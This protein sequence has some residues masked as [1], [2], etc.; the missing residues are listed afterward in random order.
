MPKLLIADGMFL[1]R[2]AQSGFGL[3]DHPVTFNFF[4]GF[5]ALVEKHAPDSV[6]FVLEGKTDR[7]AEFAD[8]KANRSI[9]VDQTDPESVK[10]FKA[11]QE[12]FRQ[13]D[14]IVALLKNALPVVV[15]RHPRYEADDVI[16]TM[17]KLATDVG[18]EVIIVSGDSDFNQMLDGK[19]NL[20][21]WNP[22]EKDWVQTPDCD[23]LMWKALKG[24][25]SDNIP[26]IPGVGAVTASRAVTDE[27]FREKLLSEG[28][29]RKTFERNL[30]LIKLRS[31]SA[32]ELD[33]LER[34]KGVP[35]WVEAIDAF[36]RW[37]F[38]SFFKQTKTGTQW[39][40]FRQVFGKLK[41]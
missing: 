34:S 22:I 31:L 26:G 7:K 16:Y 21:I 41:V 6:I 8:Y 35:D 18:D 37:D 11:E 25:S 32:D 23:Y 30:S 15:M 12:F 2:R 20:K 9:E 14:E 29:N 5:K 27:V 19:S 40:K 1:L 17:A 13:V 3:G 33:E 39:D 10:K 36:K 28:D 4:R 24:D 38:G